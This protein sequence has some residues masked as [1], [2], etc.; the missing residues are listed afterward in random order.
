MATSDRAQRDF[1]LDIDNMARLAKNYE[2]IFSKLDFITPY[3]ASEKLNV[4]HDEIKNMIKE[5]RIIFFKANLFTFI[6]VFQFEDNKINPLFSTLLDLVHDDIN[7]ERGKM[8]PKNLVMYTLLKS[9]EF[10]HV[11]QFGGKSKTSFNGIKYI[12]YFGE[13]GVRDVAE[14]LHNVVYH[15]MGM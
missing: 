10:H 12:E 5:N 8:Q 3:E 6:P 4:S 11:N 2:K 15:E 1:K 9:Y 13:E 14:R 7:S